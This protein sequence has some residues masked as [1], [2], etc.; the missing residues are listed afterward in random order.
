[1]LCTQDLTDGHLHCLTVRQMTLGYR[2][3]IDLPIQDEFY[4]EQMLIKNDYQN[5]TPMTGIRI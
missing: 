2:Q 1:M 5:E 3:P 4:Q